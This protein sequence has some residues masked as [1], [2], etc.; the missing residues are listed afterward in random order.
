MLAWARG[1]VFGL[2]EVRPRKYDR[3][4]LLA[5]CKENKQ[6]RQRA[7]GKMPTHR[8]KAPNVKRGLKHGWGPAWFDQFH[9]NSWTEKRM[10]PS[11]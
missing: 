1:R 3:D 9:Y 4:L 2:T 7:S 6:K 5:V 8:L 11:Y 10:G